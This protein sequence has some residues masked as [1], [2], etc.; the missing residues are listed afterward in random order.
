MR[1]TLF[2]GLV[3]AFLLTSASAQAQF[4]ITITFNENC[5]S[6][7]TN[8]SGFSST[9]PCS[10]AQDPGPGGLALALTYGLLNPPG[11]TAGDLIFPEIPTSLKSHHLT[12]NAS[13]H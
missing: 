8:T 11:L 7:F 9:L 6:S 10:F 4:S 5:N 13:P 1:Y 12:V 2:S 3:T